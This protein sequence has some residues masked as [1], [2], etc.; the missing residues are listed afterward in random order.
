[1][2][3]LAPL[4]NGPIARLWAGLSLS[5]V[6]DQLQRMALVWLSTELVGKNAGFVSAAESGAVLLTALLAGAWTERWDARRTMIGADLVRAGLAMIPVAVAATGRLGLWS[7]VLPSVALAA[8][9]GVFDP[10][11]QASLPRMTA[12]ARTLARANALMDATARIARLVGPAAAGLLTGL[13]P[14]VGLMAVNAATFVASAGAVASLRR[15]LPR[16]V[17]L[18][19]ASRLDLLLR[20]ARAMR[21]QPMFTYLLLRGG[22]VNGLW[23]VALWLGLPLAVQHG[24]LAGFGASG[25]GVVGLVMGA[26]GAGNL[27]GNLVVGGLEIRRPVEMIVAG[28]AIVGAGLA[29]MGAAVLVAPAPAVVPLMMAAAALAALGGPV[30]DVPMATLRQTAFAPGDVAAVYRLS[31]VCDHGGVLLAT[32]LAPGLLAEAK[33]AQ[34]IL[35]CGVA[36]VAVALLGLRAGRGSRVGFP[37]VTSPAA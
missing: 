18:G 2:K 30:S 20:G 21:T 34:V 35:A 3:I 23:V 27:V 29:L 24:R 19:A 37:E 14:V 32:A 10:A 6:G 13:I 8:L 31:I 17:E 12:E 26:Y 1:M 28:N 36:M 25:L 15:E 5:A 22:A 9:R 7:L 16:R 11:L 33:P 4:S